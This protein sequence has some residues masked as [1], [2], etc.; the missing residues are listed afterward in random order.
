[1]PISRLWK[2]INR[3]IQRVSGSE[4]GESVDRIARQGGAG[5]SLKERMSIRQ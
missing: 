3:R 1:M 2:D 4:K 5:D